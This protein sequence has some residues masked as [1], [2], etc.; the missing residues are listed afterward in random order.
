ME[1]ER[2]TG[3][4][5][6]P[7]EVQS[8][9]I[10]HLETGD[11]LKNIIRAIV[12]TS[13]VDTTFFKLVND[14]YGNQKGFTALVQVLANKFKMDPYSVAVHFKTPTSE[15]YIRLITE[16]FAAIRNDDKNKV[17]ELLKA[18]A[19]ANY[20]AARDKNMTPLAY[21]VRYRDADMVKELLKFG[22]NPN[23]MGTFS[24]P[25]AIFL[26]ENMPDIIEKEAKRQLLKD[27]MNK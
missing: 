27:A 23:H 5:D 24:E 21:A 15:E 4:Q 14:I 2:S 8:L 25:T 19:D 6:L 20:Y 17:T 3:M 22:A 13:Q 26:L 10:T 11:S 9:I 18:G 1:P 7:R 12:R 16:L